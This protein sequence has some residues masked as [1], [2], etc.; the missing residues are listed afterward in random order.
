[1]KQLGWFSPPGIGDKMG[2]GY[3]AVMLIKALQEHDVKVAYDNREAKCHISFIQPEFYS[4]NLDQYRVGYTP[5]E[6]S[7][8][9]DSWRETM[10]QMQEIWTPSQYCVDIFEE[11]NLNKIIR[12]VPHGI[13]PELWKIENRYLTDK[14][15]FFHVGGPTARKGGQRVVDAFLDLFDGNDDVMLILKSNEDTECRF[16]E[17]GVDFKSAAAHP[18]IVS[19]NYQVAVEDLVRLYNR[20]HCL[21]YPTNGEGFGLIPF[22]G[23]A[24]GLP[25]IVT[26]A[27]ACADFAELSVPLDSKPT[28]GVGVHLGD[29]VEPDADDLRDKMRYVYDNYNEV[30]EKTL[31]SARIIHNTQTWYHVAAQVIDI[32]GEKITQMA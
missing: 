18:Q 5:W 17:N 26:N 20:S 8:V 13:D 25:T 19:I 1:M 11:N 21:V 16:Y 32:L 3:A 6:S 10:P 24:T 27:T 2:Y 9:P 15:I 4:G 22:Q 28:K 12:K 7:V 31:E 30:K 23:I 14:F 29:W